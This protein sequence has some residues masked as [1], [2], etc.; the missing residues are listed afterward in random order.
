MKGGGGVESSALVL[1]CRFRGRGSKANLKKPL[2]PKILKFDERPRQLMS[3]E[4][5]SSSIGVGSGGMTWDRIA[6]KELSLQDFE[7]V[8]HSEYRGGFQEPQAV[9]PA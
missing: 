5:C 2:G 6:R 7:I 8:V 1:G 9:N 3:S 4:A